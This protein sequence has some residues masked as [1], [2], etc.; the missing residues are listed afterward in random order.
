MLPIIFTYT[1]L[2]L[3]P[4]TVHINYV[5]PKLEKGMKLFPDIWVYLFR[6]SV[7]PL[8]C[9]VIIG[10]V[11]CVLGFA[12]VILGLWFFGGGSVFCCFL[13]GFNH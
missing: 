1:Y 2:P 8:Q 5:H 7:H 12:V 3:F 4:L 10:P 9:M 13:V 11:L 6:T